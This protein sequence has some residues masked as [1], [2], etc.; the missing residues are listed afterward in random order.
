MFYDWFTFFADNPEFVDFK[1]KLKNEL[2][3]Y[4]TETRDPSMNN[5]S[6]RDYLPYY[7]NG[8][9]YAL[10]LSTYRRTDTIIDGLM[11]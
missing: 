9:K 4:L 6:P 2:F 3:E 5:E 10:G 8:T 1:E 7:G 11:Y